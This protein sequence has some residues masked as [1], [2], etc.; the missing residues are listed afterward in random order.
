MTGRSYA[1]LLHSRQAATTQS[2]HSQILTL[3]A[4]CCLAVATPGNTICARP[5]EVVRVWLGKYASGASINT[6]PSD[7]YST[8]A[9]DFD[10][11][12]ICS[13][14][15]T[16]D[17]TLFWDWASLSYNAS[18]VPS[19][20]F[21]AGNRQLQAAKH[22][23]E[24]TATFSCVLSPAAITYL[25]EDLIAKTNRSLNPKVFKIV[26]TN[27]CTSLTMEFDPP[28]HALLALRTNVYE[29]ALNTAINAVKDDPDADLTAD[30]SLNSSL[31]NITF[32]FGV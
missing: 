8:L 1:S 9:V 31:T 20:T 11:S 27:T 29:D 7:G 14:S 25:S 23:V 2:A 15:G 16:I 21:T 22:A 24:V 28:R 4:G 3:L 19:T 32:T 12:S 10:L 13:G 26:T 30:W 6:R 18:I 17:D 5:L